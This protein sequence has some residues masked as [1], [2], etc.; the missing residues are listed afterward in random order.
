MHDVFVYRTGEPA[1]GVL[2]DVV[3]FGSKNTV[4][5][6]V[7]GEEIDYLT[8]YVDNKLHLYRQY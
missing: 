1:V 2:Y 5:V 4:L 8:L 6:D 7:T 3:E